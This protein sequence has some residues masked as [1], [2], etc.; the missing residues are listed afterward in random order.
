MSG[1][2][3]HI[4]P[5]L[6]TSSGNP[7]SPNV[8]RV[9]TMP[10]TTSPINTTTTKNVSQ[11]LL[12]RIS[13]D[14][15]IQEEGLMSQ[16]FLHLTKRIL[17]VEKLDVEEDQRTSN[18]FIADLNAEYNKRALLEN[19]EKGLIVK[20]FNWNE[21]SFTSE[22]E[23]TTKIKAFMAIAED[24]PSVRKADVRSGQW[25]DITMKKVHRLLSMTNG[26]ERKQIL[27]YTNVDLL[28]V[29]DQRKNM[30]NKFNLLKQE[31]SL[32]KSETCSKVTLDQL[33]TEQV[34]GNI[35]KALGGKGRR[36]EKI[37]TKEV[38]FTKAAYKKRKHHRASFKTKRSF[39]IN[40]SLHL[41]HMD[42]FG[43]V[44]PQTISHNKYTI[45][46]VDEYLRKMENLNEVRVK[47]LRSDNG[48]EFRN[49]KLEKFCNEKAKTMLNSEKL[50]KQF[51]GEAVNTA[52]YTQNISIIVKR[53]EMTT[54]DVFRV[55]SSDIS[56]FYVFGC[57]VHIHNHKDHLGKFNE[58]A[59]DGFFLSYSPVAKSF[60]VF[61]IRRQKIKENIHVNFS[62]DNEA[63]SQ[64]STEGD[65]VNFN[66]NRSFL[67]NEFLKP[68]SKVT[69]CPGNIE[70]FPY[71]PAY[72][73]TTPSD[74]PILHNSVSFKEPLEFTIADDH[75]TP[76]KLDQPESDDN[77]ESAKI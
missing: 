12:M 68:R 76:N 26:D 37:S 45:V 8:N 35:I 2:V 42:L 65:A 1:T 4:P 67:D 38:V 21:A 24:E 55:R 57:P 18:E 49:H 15:L 74:L 52:Y 48:T 11:V 41:L 61:N 56:Y 54:Y 20:S 75:P 69:Q 59:N 30:V 70:Y 36:K 58:K 33:L 66:E 34:P 7:G 62:E 27:D 25:V 73:N 29:E 31:L 40:K 19:L 3:P 50:P 5:S 71:I 64:S 51:W 39:S 63:I 6:G 14:F 16:M 72:E 9:D 22:D 13:F 77:L 23:G 47:E 32:H 44:K 60:R 28:Y 43:P 53:H 10:T 17:Q 46:I